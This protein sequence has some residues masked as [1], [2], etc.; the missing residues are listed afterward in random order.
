MDK[1][2][3]KDW[4]QK[5]HMVTWYCDRE[6][7][8]LEFKSESELQKHL[9]H[10]HTSLREAHVN[11]LVRRNWGVG[12]REGYV[13]PLCESTPSNIVP[14]MNEKD[15]ASL[16]SRHIG[17]HLKALALFSLPSLSTDPANDEQ[18]SSSGAQLPTNGH[19]Q[20]HS[21]GNDQAVAGLD[22]DLEGSL[23]FDDDP[24]SL[25]DAVGSEETINEGHISEVSYDHDATLE[26]KFASSE[27]VAPE[28][29]PVL[30]TLRARREEKKLATDSTELLESVSLSELIH[31]KAV[32]SIFDTSK[33]FFPNG[34]FDHLITKESVTR[35]LRVQPSSEVEQK[36]DV[37]SLAEFISISAKRLF[38]ILVFLPDSSSTRLTRQR[39]EVFRDHSIT[40]SNLPLQESWWKENL[41]ML[42]I[43][44]GVPGLS[45][46]NTIG[47]GV[48]WPLSAVT[49]FCNYQHWFLAPVF[50]SSGLSYDLEPGAILP[51]T[52][53]DP[54]VGHST[55][56][57]RYRIHEKH[58]DQQAM[59]S[60]DH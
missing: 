59:V 28:L 48:M 47:Y 9:N 27:R 52:E 12:C 57:I 13:C 54:D 32:R 51:F 56:N 18:K 40:D 31:T 58:I 41:M 23:T 29:D 11:A 37:E 42:V 4:P 22:Q 30:E 10:D 1:F 16:L 7:H 36:T 44:G 6:H 26:W 55:W 50:S 19:S 20:A 34:S 33:C 5:V 49:D 17:D 15:K 8:R 35:E 43:E 39:M 25:R 24:S 38:G 3:G 45:N 21:A 2:H 14:L 53:R 60:F 46:R